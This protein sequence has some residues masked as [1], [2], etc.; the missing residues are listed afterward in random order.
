[1]LKA[2]SLPADPRANQVNAA[3]KGGSLPPKMEGRSW[4]EVPQ[5]DVPADA[6]HCD[7]NADTVVEDTSIDPPPID[8]QLPAP[9]ARVKDK[10][11]RRE[12]EKRKRKKS[13]EQP[14][15]QGKAKQETGSKPKQQILVR[16]KA[17][18]C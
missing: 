11:R 9:A 14:Q 18:S 6:Q 15:S 8:I 2:A 10:K 13:L 4:Q 5:E 7:Q 1:M 17:I 3:Q 16:S 12:K